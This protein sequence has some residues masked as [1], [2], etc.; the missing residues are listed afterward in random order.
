MILNTKNYST[1]VSDFAA[2]VQGSASTLL[3]FLVGSVLRAI[4]QSVA[5]VVMWLQG[6]VLQLL[7]VTRLAS[8]SGTDVDSFLSD[9]GFSRLPSVQAVGLVTFSRAT[10]TIAASIPVG[11]IVAS[12]DGSQQFA[13]I[14]DPTNTAY[15][16]GFNAYLLAVNVA[17]VNVTVQAVNGGTGGNVSAGGI[18]ILQTGVAG[19]DTVTNGSPFT[20]GINAESDPAVKIRF[21]N[22]L[23]SLFNASESALTFAIKSVNQNLQ[24]QIVEQTFGS[25][26]VLLYVDDGS[27]SIA[28]ALVSAASVAANKVRAA[29]III[30]VLAASK[31][32]ANV[33]F[34]IATAPGY[35]H[36]TVVGQAALAVTS[37]INGIGLNDTPADSQLSYLQLA[38]IAFGVPGVTDVTQLLLNGGN[39]D[40]VPASGQTIKAGTVTV[41]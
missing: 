34:V 13:V 1:L 38:S 7:T 39:V 31:L 11:A 27:G 9:F 26:A 8:S 28:G 36:N 6:L 18:S 25:P 32:T 40:L 4:G 23:A 37:F 19:V 15:N 16:A 14:A 2:A 35:V 20:T 5:S 29:G 12:G 10:P 41:S 33:S 21:V 24:V 17:S 30:G 3:N 22:Y